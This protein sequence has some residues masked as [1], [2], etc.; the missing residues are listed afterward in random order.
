MRNPHSPNQNN[1]YFMFIYI[2]PKFLQI[3]SYVCLTMLQRIHVS[4]PCTN[5]KRNPNSIE[6]PNVS[7]EQITR[8]IQIL[9]I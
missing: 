5:H 9:G 1:T 8:D 4:I 7:E 6:T 2:N 3:K